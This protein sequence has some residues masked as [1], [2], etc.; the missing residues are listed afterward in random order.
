MSKKTKIPE[1][2]GSTRGMC[3]LVALLAILVATCR[4][5]AAD[6]GASAEVPALIPAPREITL[7]GGTCASAAKPKVERVAGIPAEGYELSVKP[8]GVTIRA[9][10][11][12]GA[13]YALQTLEQLRSS[14]TTPLPCCEIKDSP[15]FKWRGVQL[16]DSRHFMGKEQVLRTIDEMTKYKFNVFHWHLTD[17]PSW[18]IEVPGYPE[19][20]DYGD[21]CRMSKDQKPMGA[22]PRE[23]H[24]YYTADEIREVV[25]YA[26]KRHVTIV[27]EVEFPGHFFAAVCAYPE[28]ACDPESVKRKN[29]LPMVCGV[30]RDV[31]CVGNPDAVKFVEAAL[32]TV[33]DLFPSKVIHIGGD[34]CPRTAWEKCPKCR[35]LMEREGLS[36]VG[37]IQTWLTRHV[38]EYLAKKGR[39]AIGWDEMLDAKEGAL[40]VSTMGMRWCPTL[41]RTVRAAKA[42]HEIVNCPHA[43]CYLDFKQGLEGDTH[44]Y[45][46][47]RHIPLKTVYLFDPLAGMPEEVRGKIVGGQC[48]NWTEYTASRDELEWKMWPRALAMAEV[49]WTYPD[50]KKRDFAD[51]KRRAAIHR[52]AMVARGINAAPIK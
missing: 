16:D 42:G 17:D 29:R 38:A 4:V 10:D 22:S 25:A 12:A 7:T 35:A 30:Q 39:R 13:F 49:L 8:D 40:P 34:E 31:M 32:D 45:M 20:L 50:P 21:Q 27:P 33:C 47:K 15:R 28:F 6:A 24:R 2:V 1:W 46:G 44:R 41:E 18:R 36:D 52:D 19:L 48:C 23:G 37:D 11:K 3:R 26:A 14:G 5:W 51:F 9:S 43:F